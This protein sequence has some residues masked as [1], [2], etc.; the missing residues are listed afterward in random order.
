MYR[1]GDGAAVY[2]VDGADRAVSV[3]NRV[4]LKFIGGDGPIVVLMPEAGRV[5]TATQLLAG[6]PNAVDFALGAD[7][8]TLTT[9]VTGQM[10]L[11]VHMEDAAVLNFVVPAASQARLSAGLPRVS[12]RRPWMDVVLGASLASLSALALF[13]LWRIIQA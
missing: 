7:G 4:V 8:M 3:D 5:Q 10:I 11:T 1:T 12:A 13:E 6:H 9:D 2:E